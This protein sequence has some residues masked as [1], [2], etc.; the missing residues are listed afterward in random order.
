MMTGKD[1]E[2]ECRLWLSCC[3]AQPTGTVV[4]VLV[5]MCQCVS[6][7]K[8]G[9]SS[10]REQ[11]ER[12]EKRRSEKFCVCDGW[13]EL[14]CKT[15]PTAVLVVSVCQCVSVLIGESKEQR[16]GGRSVVIQCDGWWSIMVVN[17]QSVC[18]CR[19]THQFFVFGVLHPR[20][21]N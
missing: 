9:V 6:G 12:R 14:L 7:V 15:Q 13:R 10:V 20:W 19:E 2:L 16:D 11:K 21:L 8:G 17:G 1:G 5:S 4:S 3:E 18:C